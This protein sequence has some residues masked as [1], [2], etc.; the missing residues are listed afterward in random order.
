M[1]KIDNLGDEANQLTRIVLDD[2]SIVLLNFIYRGATQRWTVNITRN[3]FTVNDIN[4]CVHPNLLRDFREN[5][6]FGLALISTDGGDP[7]LIN[8]FTSGRITMY[9]L[10]A[11]DV[12]LVETDIFKALV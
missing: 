9:T 12:S 7:V 4:L 8:D 2:G 1:N 3:D 6:P 11:A 5:I 10:S